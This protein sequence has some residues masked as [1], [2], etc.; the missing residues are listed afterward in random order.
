MCGINSQVFWNEYFSNYEI[1]DDDNAIA[2]AYVQSWA[3][4]LMVFV[5]TGFMFR[6]VTAYWIGTRLKCAQ[7]L[8][9]TS[10]VVDVLTTSIDY[11]NP[12]AEEFLPSLWGAIHLIGHYA[13]TISSKNTKFKLS[14]KEVVYMFEEHGYEAEPLLKLHVKNTINKLHWGILQSI[15]KERMF[16]GCMESMDGV[17]YVQLLE[18]M[19]LM[20]GGAMS[21]MSC[22]SSNKL[23]FALFHLVNWVVSESC[24]TLLRHC[25]LGPSWPT[26]NNTLSYYTLQTRLMIFFYLVTVYGAIANEIKSRDGGDG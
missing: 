1:I 12:R 24:T 10:K 13:F 8:I 15:K 17:E 26:L 22:T 18:S 19:A 23:P 25:L 5:L 11:D 2:A 3:S 16:G 14:K 20:S 21:T 7:L 9:G 4:R 6:L